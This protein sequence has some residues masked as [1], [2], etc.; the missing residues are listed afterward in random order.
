MKSIL[1]YANEDAGQSARLQAA[2]ELAR[3]FGAHITCLQVT[4]YD[5]FVAGDPF[6]GVYIVPEILETVAKLKDEGRARLEPKLRAAEVSWSWL[7]LDGVPERCLLDQSQLADVVV[8][9]APHGTDLSVRGTLAIAGSVCVHAR[10]A[11][12][13]VPG[14][15][16]GKPLDC[17]GV[18]LVAWNG[19]PEAAHALRMARPMLAHASAV[20]IVSVAPTAD[21][22]SIDQ[23]IDYLHLHGIT[24]EPHTLD[25]SRLSVAEAI[26]QEAEARSAR[27]IVMGAYGHARLREAVLGGVTRDMLR[28]NDTPM[29]LSH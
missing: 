11:V 26:I 14:S 17:R 28:L 21:G 18:A 23:A 16:S 4:P 12:L 20:H 22:W 13:A 6:S 29:L 7:D 24:A 2:L 15:G 27:Y 25:R 1:L 5:A 19:S 8:I 10:S 3:T 9:S